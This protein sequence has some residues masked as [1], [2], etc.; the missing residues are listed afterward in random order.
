MG[1]TPHP[2]PGCS[3]IHRG[4]GAFGTEKVEAGVV[5]AAKGRSATKGR[6]TRPGLGLREELMRELEA[7]NW[8]DDGIQLASLNLAWDAFVNKE[9]KLALCER[10]GGPHKSS[11]VLK[12]RGSKP[13]CT[14]ECTCDA[15]TGM[16]AAYLWVWDSTQVS[17]K[18]SAWKTEWEKQS[19]AATAVQSLARGREEEEC[20]VAGECSDVTTEDAAATLL[21][22][23][24]TTGAKRPRSPPAV[25]WDE[26]VSPARRLAAG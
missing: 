9:E 24:Q 20:P 1:A 12:F 14:G 10:G 6:G 7:P 19:A 4:K 5:R 16:M 8:D 22:L 23:A 13:A 26:C 21:E 17:K 25:P 2:P 18:W 15:D 11:L 3:K